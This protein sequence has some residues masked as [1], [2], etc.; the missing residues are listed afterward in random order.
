MRGP[1]Q[2]LKSSNDTDHIRMSPQHKNASQTCVKKARVLCAG[3]IWTRRFKLSVM[4]AGTGSHG[5]YSMSPLPCL[6][7]RF[8]RDFRHE[9]LEREIL[10][11]EHRI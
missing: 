4:A 3:A 6:R 7:F 11:R 8:F 9:R 5:L 10:E 2:A 1:I